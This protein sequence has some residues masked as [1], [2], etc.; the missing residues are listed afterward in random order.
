MQCNN[1]SFYTVVVVFLLLAH[2][3]YLCAAFLRK[4]TKNH[5]PDMMTSLPT[6]SSDLAGFLT[7][8]LNEPQRSPP[9]P[10]KRFS[11]NGVHSDTDSDSVFNGTPN[12]KMNR[13]YH[14]YQR[15]HFYDIPGSRHTRVKTYPGQDIPGSRHTRVK[16]Y[17][18]QDKPGHT[19][20]IVVYFLHNTFA[21]IR[22]TRSSCLMTSSRAPHS[23][24]LM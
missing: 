15:A 10:K 6:I 16:T 11:T 4:I 2:I 13:L 22:R 3:K 9:P 21:V 24:T 20:V 1:A 5:H 17:P 14:Y 8:L 7:I 18:G 19:A 23:N 12:A